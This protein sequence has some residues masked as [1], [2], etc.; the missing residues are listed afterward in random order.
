MSGHLSAPDRMSKMPAAKWPPLLRIT[1]QVLCSVAMLRSWAWRSEL[2]GM[3]PC[4]APGVSW[5]RTQFQMENLP[6]CEG[7]S[8]NVFGSRESAFLSSRPSVSESAGNG[9]MGYDAAEQMV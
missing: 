9:R 6:P 5:K 4:S 1:V 2:G 7:S 8:N 3:G